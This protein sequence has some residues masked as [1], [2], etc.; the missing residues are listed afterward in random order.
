MLIQI[1]KSIRIIEAEF[2]NTLFKYFIDKLLNISKAIIKISKKANI[3]TVL[4]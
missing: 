4:L 3:I 2:I 1:Q